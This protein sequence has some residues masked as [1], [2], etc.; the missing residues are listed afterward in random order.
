MDNLEQ[1]LEDL[2]RDE[3]EGYVDMCD[4]DEDRGIDVKDFAK[5]AKDSIE[6]A[7]E[8]RFDDYNIEA[9]AIDYA[10]NREDRVYE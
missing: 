3:Y 8:L 7:Y 1:E 9:Y 5:C 2:I 4:L 6:K 10:K